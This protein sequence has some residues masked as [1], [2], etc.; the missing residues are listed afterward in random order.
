[1]SGTNETQGP[2]MDETRA[3]AYSAAFEA[4]ADG[5]ESIDD[6]GDNV[7]PEFAALLAYIEGAASKFVTEM[8]AE[9]ASTAAG[10][11]EPELAEPVAPD[12][13][14]P[15]PGSVEY[16]RRNGIPYFELI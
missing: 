13:V 4:A 7:D 12:E 5:D 10:P 11:A 14:E 16:D 15:E 6:E 2:A 8:R 9:A 1:M 3:A